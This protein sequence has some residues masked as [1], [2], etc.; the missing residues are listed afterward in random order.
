M[1]YQQLKKFEDL[2]KPYFDKV[3]NDEKP[4]WAMKFLKI[5]GQSIR[6]PP[7]SIVELENII[8]NKNTWN[9]AY[10]QFQK[11]RAFNL[12]NPKF[13]NKEYLIIAELTAK[14]TYNQTSPTTPFDS[15]SGSAIPFLALEIAKIKNDLKMENKIKMLLP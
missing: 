14:L 8:K 5:V 4:F 12:S 6:N 9:Q 11:I 13:H 3:A 2:G 7:L 15:S 10:N 1:N